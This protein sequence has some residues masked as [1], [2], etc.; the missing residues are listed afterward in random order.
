MTG[1]RGRATPITRPPV[2]LTVAIA[3]ACAAPHATA[4]PA[5]RS[6]PLT[7]EQAAH[8]ATQQSPIVKR[9]QAAVQ[10]AQAN[11]AQARTAFN[12]TISA[13]ANA[14]GEAGAGAGPNDIGG[15]ASGE[16]DIRA[17][18]T[19]TLSA[20]ANATTTAAAQATTT[21]SPALALSG[22]WK[23]WP[24]SQQSA[25]AAT[26]AS[27]RANLSSANDKLA[28]ARTQAATLAAHDYQTLQI[29]R[30]RTAIARGAASAAQ[31]TL[32]LS[33]AQAGQGAISRADL[34]QAQADA[35]NAKVDL[36]KA[37]DAERTDRTALLHD[38]GLDDQQITL[39]AWHA[40]TFTPSAI[41]EASLHNLAHHHDAKML[42]AQ[43]K[44][45]LARAA[46]RTA[47][48]R[49]G[50]ALTMQTTV[51]VPNLKSAPTLTLGIKAD[52][53]V[54]DG[55]AKQAAID[56]AESD[57]ATAQQDLRDTQTN[58]EDT[59]DQQLNALE[60][61]ALEIQALRFTRDRARLLYQ[62]AQAQARTGA[63]TSRDLL[64]KQRAA[65]SAQLDLDAAVIDYQYQADNLKHAPGES[66]P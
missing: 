64:A 12:P 7:L 57:L 59:V 56:E 46:V 5:T 63:I 20:Q 26:L 14:S 58:V 50:L 52:F 49:T 66:P 16:L 30:Q 42:A 41:D 54:A 33:Q 35:A 48:S 61:Q 47:Q 29:A 37:T 31:T 55:G 2:L 1:R 23:A 39:E 51:T 53:T 10:A 21:T 44:V 34:L 45:E 36:H 9:A 11:L 8:L 17:T 3:I 38:T 65:M 28:L 13:S 40:P 32:Q 25:A 19:I 43:R 22:S 15:T 62:Q 4:A 27:A 24:P 60:Q 18:P 6:A